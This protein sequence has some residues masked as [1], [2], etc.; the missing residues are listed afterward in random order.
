[1][2]LPCGDWQWDV[3]LL[4]PSFVTLGKDAF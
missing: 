3:H 2:V 1:M 4:P